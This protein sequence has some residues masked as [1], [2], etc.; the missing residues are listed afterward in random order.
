MDVHTG[1]AGTGDHSG[2]ECNLQLPIAQDLS[3]KRRPIHDY[4]RGRK[5]VGPVYNENKAL[6]HLKEGDS[7]YRERRNAWCWPRASAQGIQC[8]ATL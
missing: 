3:G 4:D 2:C 5:N 6:L 7:G 8:I 1:R